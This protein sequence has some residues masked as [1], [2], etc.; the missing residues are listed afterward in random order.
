MVI[1]DFEIVYTISRN[2]TDY[3]LAP[4]SNALPHV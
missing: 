4:A 3:L 2:W 1:E